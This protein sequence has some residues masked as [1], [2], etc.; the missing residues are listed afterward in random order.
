MATL[1]DVVRSYYDRHPVK[2]WERL[3]IHR[4]EFALTKRALRQ[5][6]PS[7]PGAV[8][9]VGGG[10]GRYAIAM[11]RW[12]HAVTLVD[13]S[14]GCL[15]FASRRA[16]EAGVELH[17]IVQ[18]NALDLGAFARAAFDAALL[19][20]PLYHL[21]HRGERRRAVE[22]VL[23]IVRPG[24]RLFAAFITRFAPFRHAV[25]EEPEWVLREPEYARLVLE[26]GVHDQGQELPQAYFA[27]P[28]EVRPLM[29]SC[30]LRTLLLLGC[31]GIASGHEERINQLEGEAW[32]VWVDLNYRL[33][34]EASLF[35]ASE[36]LLYV[37]ERP[38]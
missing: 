7:P 26:T 14:E 8:V 21:L 13:L 23:R 36:H 15:T 3:Q 18:A 12:G 22:E 9:D 29:E 1:T 28:D 34:Q 25:R 27:R 4:T 35:G 30:G 17:G 31:E 24:G 19:L 38:C 33:G 37:G 5:Y 20:G 16:A 11:T 6:L 10:P 32:Q 2:E